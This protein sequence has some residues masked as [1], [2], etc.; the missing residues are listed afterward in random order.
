[1]AE[2]N[3]GEKKNTRSREV[4]TFLDQLDTD[5]KTPAAA[6][7]SS[8]ESN[9]RK[10]EAEPQSATTEEA[11]KTIAYLQNLA[12]TK[13]ASSPK[14]GNS[15]VSQKENKESDDQTPTNSPMINKGKGREEHSKSDD[16][17]DENNSD[18]NSNGGGYWS[19]WF[20]VAQTQASAALQQ[21][22]ETAA[23]QNIVQNPPVNTNEWRAKLGGFVKGAGL[24]KIAHDLAQTG[25][26]ALT[27]IMNVVI[28][29][30][31]DQ[32]VLE[33]WISHDLV[34]YDGIT[35]VVYNGLSKTLENISGGQLIV[36]STKSDS[37]DDLRNLNPLDNINAAIQLTEERLNLLLE[38]DDEQQQSN[39]NNSSE[40]S[41]V[42]QEDQESN[43]HNSDPVKRTP[44]KL[45][46][47]PYIERTTKC[48]LN[49]KSKDESKEE[50][51]LKFMLTLV[52]KVHGLQSTSY[53]QS[54]PLEWLEGEHGRE[55][56][57]KLD[58]LAWLEDSLINIL[59]LT[60]E[61]VGTDYIRK[62]QV[63]VT[64]LVQK[65]DWTAAQAQIPITGI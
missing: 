60:I 42:K 33:V 61:N 65:A 53:S 43:E 39:E 15:Q 46:I 58:Y 56:D 32:E 29:P 28:P 38:V 62:R 13:K 21:A 10:D 49:I 24:D 19:S 18:K 9:E 63:D 64:K 54:I 4:M 27:D 1:M 59:K 2:N 50:K 26:T 22:K 6:I 30:I 34:G 40:S 23:K 55:G 47:Q 17:N 44:L 8:Q 12:T 41:K 36:N 57:D 7:S 5:L 11:E 51:Y 14:L 35:D 25:K 31:T 16:K 20:S 3:N 45:R 52:D 48:K 37:N